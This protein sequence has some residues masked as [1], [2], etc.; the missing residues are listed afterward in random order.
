LFDAGDP[1][2]WQ[3][4]EFEENREILPG[5][6]Q[7]AQ[8]VLAKLAR[9]LDHDPQT[10]IPRLDLAGNPY[11]PP[12]LACESALLPQERCVTLLP[13]ALSCT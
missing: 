6:L 12:E 7:V 13:L 4:S 2:G 11:W 9:L 1:F 10:S 5:L 8:Q 3:I